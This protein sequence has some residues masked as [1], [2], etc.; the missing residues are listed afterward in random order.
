MRQRRNE[1]SE[2][3]LKLLPPIARQ[4][5]ALE[6]VDVA[7]LAREAARLAPRLVEQRREAAPLADKLLRYRQETR[8]KRLRRGRGAYDSRPLVEEL[9]KRSLKALFENPQQG[10]ELAELAWEITLRLARKPELCGGRPGLADLRARCL[11]YLGN[12]LRVTCRWEDAEEAFVDA[13]RHRDEGIG[14]EELHA[15]ILSMHG[16]LLRDRRRFEEALETLRRAEGM[17]RRLGDSSLAGWAVL[18]RAAIL[19]TLGDSEKAAEVYLEAFRLLDEEKEPLIAV[20][21]WTNLAACYHDLGRNAEAREFLAVASPLLG[22]CPPGST[23]NLNHA[24]ARGQVA[25]G[26]GEFS[27]AEEAFVKALAGFQKLGDTYNQA[28]LCLEVAVLWVE[29]GRFGEVESLAEGTFE[30]LQREGLHQEALAAFLLFVEAARKR[31]VTETVIGFAA[32]KL[33]QHSRSGLRNREGRLEAHSRQLLARGTERADLV[34]LAE[35]PEQ[36]KVPAT[37]GNAEITGWALRWLRRYR[38]MGQAEVAKALGI[39][40]GTLSGWETGSRQPLLASLQSLLDVL[41]S[42]FQD[43]QAAL[44]VVRLHGSQGRKF[45]RRRCSLLPHEPRPMDHDLLRAALD[46]APG[47]RI[48]AAAARKVLRMLMRGAPPEESESEE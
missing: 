37:P 2:E 18:K 28:L 5:L 47:A 1:V 31:H 8:L 6:R 42:D 16:S 12:A 13:F 26:L 10:Y 32:E 45:P 43:L 46:D 3:L 48:E 23:V 14:E 38:G 39:T 40:Q 22:L 34:A 36:R 29:Q 17:Y 30:A 7:G 41:R 35:A 27:E 19:K 33:R 24:W 25:F 15:E 21:A 20:A 11:A 44:T 9:L 4:R